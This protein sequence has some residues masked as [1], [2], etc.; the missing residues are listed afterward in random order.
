VPLVRV[1]ALSGV[2]VFGVLALVASVSVGNR[3]NPL[4]LGIIVVV[5]LASW[6]YTV[7]VVPGLR[8]ADAGRR[9]PAPPRRPPRPA[10]DPST[11]PQ[12]PSVP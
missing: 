11:E 9:G 4:P 12:E 5:G 8:A 7:R 10:V 6:L 1:A 2:A 3:F